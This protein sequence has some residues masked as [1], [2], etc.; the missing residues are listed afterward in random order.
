MHVTGALQY[1]W[2]EVRAPVFC[3]AV[4]RNSDRNFASSTSTPLGP[5]LCMVR[6]L[7]LPLGSFVVTAP[8]Q[9][10]FAFE[11]DQRIWTPGVFFFTVYVSPFKTS[12][13]PPFH[14]DNSDNRECWMTKHNFCWVWL[15]FILVIMLRNVNCSAVIK[16]SDNHL[17][18]SSTRQH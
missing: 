4:S 11:H 5:W 14:D 10:L 18:L 2:R 16:Y 6:F 8:L 1:C 3:R 13:S 9:P 17:L 7:A 12:F 15:G